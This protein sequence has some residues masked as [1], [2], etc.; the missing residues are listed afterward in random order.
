MQV[1]A[2]NE[3]RVNLLAGVVVRAGGA[4][5]GGQFEDRNLGTLANPQS[6]QAFYYEIFQQ[7]MGK[8]R[9]HDSRYV[10]PDS[11]G[12]GGTLS[13]SP[14]SSNLPSVFHTLH[15]GEEEKFLLLSE[16]ASS[17]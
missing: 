1:D 8:V 15:S 17:R 7:Y 5:G 16:F 4:Q 2:G 12:L 10:P 14:D 13:L 9:F 6:I 11:I 3:Q